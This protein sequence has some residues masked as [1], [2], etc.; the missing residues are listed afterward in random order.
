M[1]YTVVIRQPVA[2]NVRAN[3]EKQLVERFNLNPAQAQKLSNRRA[4]RLM[5]PTSQA[6]AELLLNVFQSVGAQVVLEEVREDAENVSA[7]AFTSQ[8]SIPAIDDAVLAPPL[9]NETAMSDF[10]PQGQ[11]STSTPSEASAFEAAPTT[12]PA[13][14]SDPFAT[15]MTDPDELP[16]WA[17]PKGATAAATAAA[18]SA[19]TV[20]ATSL[21]P[22][23]EVAATK[24][25]DVS[26][27]TEKVADAA[28]DD[29][30]DFAGA[31]GGD[32]K[33][34]AEDNEKGS[35]PRQ[36]TEF[37]TAVTDE[38]EA[39]NKPRS[40][41]TKQIRL[42]TL[43]P[44]ILAGVLTLGLLAVALPHLQ[45]SQRQESATNLALTAGSVLDLSKPQKYTDQLEAMVAS[46]NVGFVRLETPDSG[47][48]VKAHQPQEAEGLARQLVDFLRQNPE[49]GRLQNNNTNY[50]VR[51]VAFSSDSL[52]RPI[53]TGIDADRVTHHF[54]V[55]LASNQLNRNLIMTLALVVIST[56][57]GLA[58]ASTFAARASR[59]VINPLERLV[60]VADAISLG[61]LTRPV[62]VERNDE[63]G[64][65]A[66]ALERM[67]LS[68]EAA[69]DRLRR[70]KR[71]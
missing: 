12:T 38:V 64:D 7:Q 6:R 5:K 45:D 66:Q 62:K 29:W 43:L 10:M 57:I 40:S 42:A 15:R 31:F 33:Q 59:S 26:T 11:G 14:A 71:S 13:E 54:T 4:G 25:T 58:L 32:E 24:T 49:G 46:P 47:I 52:G 27:A 70:R 23:G 56:L 16:N 30:A 3:L 53:R 35:K 36:T 21:K 60:K 44:L 55:G 17:K 8:S 28:K 69:M 19:A 18:A 9:K 50:Y 48:I 65:L 51:R 67:R 2:D 68:L 61:D 20:S 37:L 63:I 39:T 41:L 22:I 34:S 1:K